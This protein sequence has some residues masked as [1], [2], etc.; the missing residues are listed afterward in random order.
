MAHFV[1]G[2]YLKKKDGKLHIYIRS[3]T[4][5]GKLRSKNYVGRTYID[6]KQKV[7]SSS[8]TNKKEAIKILEKW[9]D[10]LQ[11]KKELG[12]GIHESSFK[13]CLKEFLKDINESQSRSPNT[14]RFI[15]QRFSVIEKCKDLMKLPVNNLKVDDIN[16]HFLI[17]RM[18]KA[19]QQSKV[20]RGATIKGDLVAISG[21]LSWCYR[22]GYRQ[23]KIEGLTTQLLSK[24]LR[25][26][27]TQRTSFTKEEYN[28]LLQ[29]SKKRYKNGRSTRIR[30]ERERLHHFIIFMVGTGLRVD[31]ALNLQWDDVQMMDRSK[32]KT[33]KKFDD[34]F[35]GELER[36]YLSINVSQ[37]KTNERKAYGTGSAYFAFKNL[38]RLYKETNFKKVGE[39]DIF[40]VKSFRDGLNALLNECN[41][42][43]SKIGE[44]KVK[45][46]AKSF[47]NTFIQFMLDKGMNTTVVAKI[48]GTSTQM[49][50][51]FYTAN[52]ALESMLDTFNKIS[53][54]HL[55]VVN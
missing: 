46:D 48:C 38:I 37:S 55:K 29:A 22:K 25:H 1:K 34:N 13:D 4:Y 23:K 11:F 36:Y 35:L 42:K 10:K 45:R 12:L 28:Q 3:D 17:W 7:I 33:L 30:F 14:I 6:K 16:K 32:I 19:K 27:R 54:S 39:G 47:R 44:N 50:D 18:N 9:Y 26:Q 2:T 8:T 21:F 51:K 5:K 41:L 15:R 43:F 49:I 31:E 40:D 20:L 52:M 53:R 24:K